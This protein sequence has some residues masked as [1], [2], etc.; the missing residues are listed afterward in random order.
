MKLLAHK[1]YEL[2]IGWNERGFDDA[3]FFRL[4]E[5]FDVNVIEGHL[6]TTGF[7]YRL[8]GRDFIVVNSKLA[9]VEKL[10]VL[11]HELGHF[12]LHVPRSGPAASFFEI[13]RSTRK[14]READ[15]FALCAL[16]PKSTVDRRGLDGLIHDGYPHEIV[17]RR[18]QVRQ[19]HGF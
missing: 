9:G 18:L 8:L 15:I 3:K 10:F 13:G 2:G 12:L 7:Y 14:E 6:E 16:L 4:C 19:R 11:L 1:L 17:E 5:A